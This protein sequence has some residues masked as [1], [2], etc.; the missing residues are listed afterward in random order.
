[1]GIQLKNKKKHEKKMKV[2]I[3][4]LAVCISLV[5][6]ASLN[7]PRLTA[8]EQEY[9][10]LF[11]QVLPL[12]TLAGDS[13]IQFVWISAH[14]DQ[15]PPLQQ[16]MAVSILKDLLHELQSNPGSRKPTVVGQAVLDLNEAFVG[17]GK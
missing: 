12:V 9:L 8:L 11:E 1:M 13:F 3:I 6:S 17:I 14:I 4:L 5:S 2:S 15:V 7:K 16:Q 10:T